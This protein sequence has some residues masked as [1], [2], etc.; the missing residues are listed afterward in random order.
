[1]PPAAI[2]RSS[3]YFPK[4]C[5]NIAANYRSA[6]L[7]VLL[8]LPGCSETTASVTT[9][10]IG[11]HELSACPIPERGP[12]DPSPFR[13]TLTALGPFPASGFD[14]ERDINLNRAGQEL[15]FN[16]AT[17][18][19]DA[20]ANDAPVDSGGAFIGHSERRDDDHIDVLLWPEAQACS[21]LTPDAG[22]PGA[23][24]GQALGFSAHAGVALVAGE[25]ADDQRSGSTL[26]FDT[27]TG[28]ATVVPREH[29]TLRVSRAFATITE[30]GDGL[31]VAG[32]TDP[33]AAAASEDASR[34][35]EIYQPVNGGFDPTLIELWS[36]RTRHAALTLPATGET[37]LVG[38]IAPDSASSGPG[39]LIRQLEAVSPSTLS[40]SISGLATLEL[41]RVDPVALVLENGLLLVGGGYA[42]SSDPDAPRGTPIGEVEV[43]SPGATSHAFRPELPARAER[44]FAALPGGG[45]LSVASCY[46][47]ASPQ[48][49][50]CTCI[51][52]DGTACEANNDD[53]AWLD[54]W[55]I[56]PDGVPSPV[57]FAPGGV[58]TPCPTSLHPLLVAGSDGAPWLISTR[59]DGTPACL[60]RFEAWPEHLAASANDTDPATEPRFVMTTLTLEPSPDARSLPLAFGPDAFLWVGPDGGL[61]GA[62]F[63]QRGPLTRD[64][65]LL[66]NPPGSPF[67]PAHL[68]P[69]RDPRRS[70]TSDGEPAVVFHAG[71]GS[72]TLSPADPSVTVWAADTLYDGATISIAVEPPDAAAPATLP[73]VVFAS[74][75]GALAVC[76][77]NPVES[78]IT[79]P[80]TITASRAN[81]RVTLSAPNAPDATCEVPTGPLAIG[82]RAGDAPTTLGDLSIARLLLE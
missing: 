12:T 55:W 38:G 71:P 62:R 45:A 14:V 4:I 40:S 54:A 66:L 13:L 59:D 50:D 78:A 74:V 7:A 26:E 58:L 1:M 33:F 46:Q 6:F 68:V 9:V 80:I 37:L 32:G 11:A 36:R 3:T 76:A 60:W 8:G 23:N 35:A 79:T 67:R 24:A 2:S 64:L 34:S 16:T 52:P 63:G 25:D 43:F 65:S 21:V 73:A 31:L 44:T 81:S 5:G 27:D 53:Q 49:A 75:T 70:T 57:A 20:L 28:A 41:G 17:V 56:D 18:G 72:L 51:L 42:T 30:F 39:Q 69:D 77:W 10:S 19:V 15:P 48:R 22:Y 82:V 61:Y 29:G 47:E